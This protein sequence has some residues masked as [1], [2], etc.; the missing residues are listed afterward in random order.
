MYI[1]KGILSVVLERKAKLDSLRPLDAST[2]K[3]LR[4]ELTVEMTYNSNSIEGNTLSQ[5][6]TRMVLE[7]GITV[8]G[9]T[10]REHLEVTNHKCAM[11]RLESLVSK[12]EIEIVDILN[13][14]ALILDRIDHS[15]AGSY[16]IGRV[17]ISGSSFIPPKPSA[18]PDMMKEFVRMFNLKPEIA[19]EQAALLHME[20]VNMH[21]FT[22]GNGRTARLLLNLHLMRNGYPPIVIKKVDRR[23][24]IDA[25]VSSQSKG[26]HSPFVNFIAVYLVQALD[27]RIDAFSSEPKEYISIAEASK[28]SGYSQGHLSLLAKKGRIPARKF[29]RNWKVAINDMERYMRK[30]YGD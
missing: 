1:D 25:I 7:D 18:L 30:R 9:K 29:G 13:L 5:S 16:R 6:E 23:R 2:L 12:S 8:G 24:Y 26:D 17:Y 10:M 27:L 15:N 19:V 14:H 4:D 21:P 11:D 28:R 20:F 22:D 3:R